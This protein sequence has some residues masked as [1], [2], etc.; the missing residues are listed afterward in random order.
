MMLRLIMNLLFLGERAVVR[1]GLVGLISE[2]LVTQ[3]GWADL[4]QAR[5]RV[6]NRL[7]G[8]S[9]TCLRRATLISLMSF[10]GT[11]LYQEVRLQ[12]GRVNLLGL[13]AEGREA[14]EGRLRGEDQRVLIH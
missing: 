13:V 12:E 8:F 2:V 7:L 14:V 3:T 10:R 9:M 6:V 4:A 5:T 1:V 11:P